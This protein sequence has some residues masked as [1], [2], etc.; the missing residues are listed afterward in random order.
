MSDAVLTAL[1]G[2]VVAV[3]LGAIQMIQ[4]VLLARMKLSLGEIRDQV[5]E[6]HVAT[7]SMKDALV[8]STEKEALLR[9]GVEERARADERREVRVEAKQVSVDKRAE[10][11]LKKDIAA[12]PEKTAEKV[13]KRIKD[14]G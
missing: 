8:L 10:L 12:V 3:I 9:G 1:I 14:N 7:N 5:E 13:V 4:V 6:V 2:A 11:E